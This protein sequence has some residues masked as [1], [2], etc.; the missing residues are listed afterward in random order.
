MFRCY[1]DSHHQ[2]TLSK[3]HK[4]VSDDGECNSEIKHSD[5]STGEALRVPGG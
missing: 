3:G 5:Y 2:G 4:V 1:I